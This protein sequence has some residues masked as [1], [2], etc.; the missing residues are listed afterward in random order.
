MAPAGTTRSD[1]PGSKSR[2]AGATAVGTPAVGTH[3]PVRACGCTLTWTSGPSVAADSPDGKL[4]RLPALVARASLLQ[5][6]PS[7]ASRLTSCQLVGAAIQAGSTT[8][9]N[10]IV[11]L[12]CC[13]AGSKSSGLAVLARSTGGDN[14]L[15]RFTGCR[16]VA[17]GR[18]EPAARAITSTIAPVEMAAA[19]RPG[20]TQTPPSPGG[21]ETIRRYTAAS[22]SGGPATTTNDP[23][24]WTPSSRAASKT[25]PAGRRASTPGRRRLAES[26]AQAAPTV[27]RPAARG[28]RSGVGGTGTLVVRIR[29]QPP[30]RA[31][32]PRARA[33]PRCWPRGMRRPPRSRRRTG[34]RPLPLRPRPGG[35]WSARPG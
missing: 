18:S 20:A 24:P 1:E 13:Q 33:A 17:R 15:R 2:S 12:S 14:E 30:T 5:P 25:N 22:A 3:G 26:T 31:P 32:T 8:A 9:V 29:L 21:C 11:L 10:M 35:G 4:R 23:G 16:R 28:S 27:T 7:Y 34:G 6:V 19:V